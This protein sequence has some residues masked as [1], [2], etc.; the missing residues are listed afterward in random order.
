MKAKRLHDFVRRVAGFYPFLLAR[1][2]RRATSDDGFLMTMY[3]MMDVA[4][5]RPYL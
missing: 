3:N 2:T 4:T 5:A 1:L